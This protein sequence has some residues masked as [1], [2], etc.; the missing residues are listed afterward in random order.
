MEP[1]KKYVICATLCRFY[2]IFSLFTCVIHNNKLWNKKKEKKSF[3]IY[4]YFSV[5]KKVENRIFRHN[6][7]FRH[8][9]MY[10]QPILRK[11][12]NY[13]SFVQTLHSYLRYTDRL[14]MCF[15]VALCYII[16][17]L[18]KTKKERLNYSKKVRRRICIRDITFLAAHPTHLTKTK[19]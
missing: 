6:H 17:V 9:C 13:N 14:L 12:W 8:T 2:A 4:I 10:K 11:Q 16:R 1:F 15:L 19:V 18:S 7:I 5:S 3:C